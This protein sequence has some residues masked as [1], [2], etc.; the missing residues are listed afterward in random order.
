MKSMLAKVNREIIESLSIQKLSLSYWMDKLC[1]LPAFALV[2]GIAEDKYPVLINVHDSKTPN[3]VVWNKLA[4][5]GLRILK[6]LAE[7]VFCHHKTCGRPKDSRV[8]FIVFTRYP[9]DW[10]ELNDYGMGTT[11]NTSCIGI[12]PFSSSIAGQ[13]ANGLARFI[14]EPHGFAKNPVIVLIDGLENL[15]SVGDDFC[16]DFRMVL[17]RGRNK[18]VYV[19]GTAHKTNFRDVQEWLEGFQAEIYGSDIVDVFEMMEG[20]N[21]I[22]FYTP[23]TEMI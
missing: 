14:N 10:G 5:Q 13:V 1:P 11:G 23:K 9:E 17:L 22:P 6:V 18:Y 21:V 16:R 20:K 19:I 4:K 7:Y 2:L 15:D 3:I 8:E 12:I